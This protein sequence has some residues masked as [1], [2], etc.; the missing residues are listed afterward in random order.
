MRPRANLALSCRTQ[1]APGRPEEKGGKNTKKYNI[2][3]AD[4]PW[5]YHPPTRKDYTRGPE[6]HYPTMTTPD[7]CEL[8]VKNIADKDSILF[9]WATFPKLPDAMKVIAAWGF[10]FKTVGFVWIKTNRRANT[11]FWGMG[12]WTRSNAEICLIATKGSPKRISSRVHQI[13]ISPV[14]EHSKKPDETRDRILRLVG[15]LPRVELFAR[16]TA[17][18]WD[19]WGNEVESTIAL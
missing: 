15:D 16:Q 4:P 10:T 7:I 13:I 2:V 1:L 8:P 9:L 12:G 19:V 14:E 18:G 5:K 6:L 17:P 11:L 3:L